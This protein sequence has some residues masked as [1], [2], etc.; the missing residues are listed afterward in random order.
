MDSS[1]R[2]TVG[3]RFFCAPEIQDIY[4]PGTREDSRYNYT[5]KVDL[6]SVGATGFYLLFHTYPFPKVS[7]LVKYVDRGAKLNFPSTPEVS[8]LCYEFLGGT[9]APAALARPSAIEAIGHGWLNDDFSNSDPNTFALDAL[10]ISS[11]FRGKSDSLDIPPKRNQAEGEPDEGTT[12]T[13]TPYVKHR[14]EDE[15]GN[16][17]RGSNADTTAQQASS[18]PHPSQPPLTASVEG[19]LSHSQP[20]SNM[21]LNHPIEISEYFGGAEPVSDFQSRKKDSTWQQEAGLLIDSTKSLENAPLSQ[22]FKGGL[23]SYVND[24]K[25]DSITTNQLIDLR[26]PLSISE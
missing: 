6:W 21:E 2:T 18:Q 23:D 17:S 5:E 24:L 11:A 13:W 19:W 3:T 14:V 25:N 20:R 1:L 26:S 15:K 8:K 9:M 10:T 16:N 7:D 22:T 12:K 4:P